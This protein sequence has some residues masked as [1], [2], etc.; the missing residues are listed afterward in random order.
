MVQ[1]DYKGEKGYGH[2]IEG[3]DDAPTRDADGEEIRGEFGDQGAGAFP[4]CVSCCPPPTSSTSQSTLLTSFHSS[5]PCPLF[6]NNSWFATEIL[7]S[8]L[9]LEPRAWRKPR[10]LDFR[11]NKDRVAKF[12]TKYD[13][14]DWTKMLAGGA[15]SQ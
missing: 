8:M 14:Y 15:Q 12:K 1:F 2:I 5:L 6:A 10:R 13:K 7:G 9:E 4:R 11:H 3:I